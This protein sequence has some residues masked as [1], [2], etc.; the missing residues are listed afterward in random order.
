MTFRAGTQLPG[1]LDEDIYGG[2]VPEIAS[3]SAGD[4]SPKL[5]Y[6]QCG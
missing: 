3:K 4:I 2:R 6:W 5:V 1:L